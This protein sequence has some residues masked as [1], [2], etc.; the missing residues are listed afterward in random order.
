MRP[1]LIAAAVLALSVSLPAAAQTI[2]PLNRAEILAG[3][4]FDLKVEFPGLV[5]AAKVRLTLNGKD[6]TSVLGQRAEMIPDET[7]KGES[8]LILRDVSLNKAG[9]YVV[10]ATDGSNTQKVTWNVYATPAKARAKNVILFIGDGF[11]IGH[12]TAARILSKGIED[13]KYKSKLAM[14]DMDAMA[15]LT[16]QGTDSI[17]TDSANAASAYTTGHKTCV[18]AL[19]VYCSRAKG[20][21]EHPKVETLTEIAKR[22]GL[23]VGV[24]TNSEIEDATPA[25]MVAHTRKR[26]DYNDI[27]KMFH[28]SRIDVMMGGGSPN[29]LPKSTPGSKRSDEDN[30]IEKF[31]SSG[32][33]FATTK[34]E[35]NAA[36]SNAKTTR[37]L[38]LYNTGNIDGALDLKFLKKGSVSKFP[39]QP[40]V[41]EEMNAA[42][43]ILS[44]NKKGFVLMVE[45]SRIDKYSHSMDAERAIYDTIMLDNA[46]RAAKDW[47]KANGNDTLIMVTADHSHGVNVVGTVD[48]EQPGDEMRNKIGL[49]EAAGFPNYPAPDADGYPDKVDVSKRLRLVFANTPD[50]YETYRPYMDGENVPAVKNADGAIVANEK[51]KSVPGAIFVTGNLPNKGSRAA[52]QGVHTG[53]DVILTATGPGADKV[54]GQMENSDLFRVIADALALGKPAAAKK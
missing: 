17:I 31:Q 11:S 33:A 18:N 16:T 50:F 32:Y 52:N 47:S 54:R 40:D 23:A 30:Y 48:D 42:I 21:L 38:G 24:V 53:D 13:G 29:F 9:Q 12:R 5:D 26:S 35:M 45:S 36:A 7:G 10:E 6:Y 39:E 25:S 37:L 14:D 19:G 1:T 28:D 8:N 4:R 46:V 49:Y 15:L 34:A 20:S 51:Y 44:R 43:K 2:Y 3:S 22:Q 27:V 41:V